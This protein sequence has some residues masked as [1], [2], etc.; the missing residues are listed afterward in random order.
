M[1]LFT[2]SGCKLSTVIR[3]LRHPDGSGRE[4][5]KISRL[6]V[7][8]TL[9]LLTVITQLGLAQVTVTG[10]V[11]NEKGEPLPGASVQVLNTLGQ[12]VLTAPADAAGTARLVLPA[13]LAGGVYVVRTGS[14]AARLVVD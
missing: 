4:A 8:L 5:R 6:R 11:V 2:Q 9:I 12:V 1:K 14:Q 10:K 13:G 3:G 7:L